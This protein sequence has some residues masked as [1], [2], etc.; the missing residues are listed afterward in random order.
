MC[1]EVIAVNLTKELQVWSLN[2]F[3]IATT[4][5]TSLNQLKN[6]RETDPSKPKHF[7]ISSQAKKQCHK[8]QAYT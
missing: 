7:S 1:T 4:L 2:F 3:F 8:Y 5:E 6:R